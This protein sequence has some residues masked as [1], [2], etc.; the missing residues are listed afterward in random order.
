[1][2]PCLRPQQYKLQMLIVGLLQV[3]HPKP[4]IN[5]S[6]ELLVINSKLRLEY[7]RYT[8]QAFARRVKLDRSRLYQTA[9]AGV[10]MMKHNKVQMMSHFHFESNKQIK[11]LKL[12]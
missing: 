3:Q 6:R 8:R 1:M 9:S 2:V 12:P 5:A 4:T 10:K 7:R 11:N